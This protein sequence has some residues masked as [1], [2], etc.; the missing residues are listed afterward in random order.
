MFKLIS[1]ILILILFLNVFALMLINF[2]DDRRIILKD[3][4]NM[5][6]SKSA[7]YI[8][9]SIVSTFFFLLPFSIPFSIIHIMYGSNDRDD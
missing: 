7:S 1:D 6:K 4:T 9:I 5:F 8:V 2:R 3:L